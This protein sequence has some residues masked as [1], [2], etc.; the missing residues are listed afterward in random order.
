MGETFPELLSLVPGVSPTY[1][2]AFGLFGGYGVTNSSQSVNGG[3]GDTITWNLNG[4]DNKDNGGGGNNFV[5]ISPDALGEFRILTSNYSAESGTSSGAAVNLSLRSGTKNFH[6]RAY[7]Y[8][9]NDHLQARAFN[10]ITKP[11]LRWNN[12]GWNAGGPILIPGLNKDREKL[13]FFVSGRRNY[14]H[15]VY[16]VEGAHRRKRVLTLSLRTATT[17]AAI[18]EDRATRGRTFS[19]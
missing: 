5:N 8:W 16:V 11:K 19:C 3:R 14:Q 4:A 12:F 9:R 18:G 10:A 7:E 13:F 17:F 6:G 2:S 15:G 1:Q